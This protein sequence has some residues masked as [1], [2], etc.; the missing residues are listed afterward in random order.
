[1]WGY[2]AVIAARRARAKEL[3]TEVIGQYTG[4]AIRLIKEANL[5]VTVL[6]VDGQMCAVDHDFNT[7]RIGIV[8]KGGVVTGAQIG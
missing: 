3:L 2:S 4:D 7:D 8:V 5:D 6:S 1:M